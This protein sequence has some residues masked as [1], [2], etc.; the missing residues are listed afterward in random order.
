MITD[1]AGE[2]AVLRKEDAADSRHD[3]LTASHQ[4]AS[5]DGS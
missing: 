4:I 5:E 1:A 2:K 3:N